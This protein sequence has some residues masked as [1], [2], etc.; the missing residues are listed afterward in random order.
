M[1]VCT[2]I[3]SMPQVTGIPQEEVLC[4]RGVNRYT[5][6]TKDSSHDLVYFN[7]TRIIMH[8]KVTVT[9]DVVKGK[10][11]YGDSKVIRK[12]V[13]KGYIK[14]VSDI[15][16]L[17]TNRVGLSQE[18]TDLLVT[19]FGVLTINAIME[20]TRAVLALLENQR[21]QS[22]ISEYRSTDYLKAIQMLFNEYD[23]AYSQKCYDAIAKVYGNNDIYTALRRNPCCLYEIIGAKTMTFSQVD[24][25]CIGLGFEY[26]PGRINGICE[27][28]FTALNN[29]GI[30]YVPLDSPGGHKIR[31]GYW[32][33]PADSIKSACKICEIDLSARL[34][35]LIVH[36]LKRIV[37]DKVFHYTTRDLWKRENRI[38]E[39]C[40]SL[41]DPDVPEDYG[42]DSLKGTLLEGLQLVAVD[43]AIRQG[44]TLI[45]GAPGTGK[46]YV[47]AQICEQLGRNVI[48]LAPTG[49]AVEKLRQ[50]L[51]DP[52]SNSPTPDVRTIHS[53]IATKPETLQTTGPLRE[54]V[55]VCIDEMSMVSLMLFSQ[56]LDTL[57]ERFEKVRLVL[58]G[59]VDQLPSI[60]GGRVFADLISKSGFEPITLVDQH[61][62]ESK[63]LI[64]NAIRVLNGKC[65]E[66]DGDII[67]IINPG[68][69]GRYLIGNVE[70]ILKQTFKKYGRAASVNNSVVL[71]PTRQ[72][73][74]TVCV[75]NLNPILQKHYNPNG[76]LLKD[77]STKALTVHTGDKLINRA[78]DYSKDIYNGSILTAQSSVRGVVSN[79]NRI[80][81][82]IYSHTTG[83][84][85]H[86]NI[87][88]RDV[89]VTRDFKYR[90]ND[91]YESIL[92]CDYHKD[93]SKLVDGKRTPFDPDDRSNL[94]LA[95]ALTVHSAQGKGYETVII[96][97]HS[98]MPP[99][100]LTR[101]ILYTAL[102][103]SRKRC[104]IIA[105]P[106]ALKKCIETEDPVR[107]TNLFQNR[108]APIPIHLENISRRIFVEPIQYIL[109]HVHEVARRSP[110]KVRRILRGTDVSTRYL[111]L[112]GNLAA[113]RRPNMKAMAT[114]DSLRRVLNVCETTALVRL[115]ECMR[116]N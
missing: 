66:P 34:E 116:D 63:I 20:D 16:Q 41:S 75:N 21:D 6:V 49:T 83:G 44:I 22:L 84:P 11:P 94:D 47:I 81:A 12:V 7:A 78:N 110:N 33:G 4:S 15:R 59:D 100:L 19:R 36:N 99:M 31:L 25:L 57:E 43:R 42:P 45:T 101:K 38:R 18:A 55:T 1:H 98:S 72:S 13:Y 9:Y 112:T 73:N 58:C 39:Y 108:D 85:D 54:Q 62:A 96:V 35:E 65:I 2:T 68:R 17:L 29:Q 52:D 64:E 90:R 60:Q 76:I 71:I 24:K 86:G 28:I 50:G 92:Y 95:Y 5:L 51:D 102:T 27:H 70:S 32:S 61:R 74:L 14:K 115:L 103:R 89:P 111:A 40:Q 104:I 3:K 97:M 80:S 113:S 69:A 109:E 56:L 93:E 8:Y 87:E 67:T 48:V 114:L 46:T 30:I 77:V 82:T 107:I 10:P 88:A 23:I 91:E 53:F 37:V 105:D 26:A 79:I 106:D